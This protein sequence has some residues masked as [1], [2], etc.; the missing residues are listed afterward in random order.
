MTT[1]Q[2]FSAPLP[3][4]LLAELAT[5][6]TPTICNALEVIAPERRSVGFTTEGLTCLYPELRPMVGYARILVQDAGVIYRRPGGAN[7]RM[8]ERV[9]HGRVR[10]RGACAPGPAGACP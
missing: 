9:A 1:K 3:A 6:D 7:A 8:R 5:F 2:E 4:D 10:R